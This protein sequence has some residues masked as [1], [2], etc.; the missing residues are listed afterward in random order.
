MGDDAERQGKW[1]MQGRRATGN[2]K[3]VSSRE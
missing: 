2:Q 1:N 3:T